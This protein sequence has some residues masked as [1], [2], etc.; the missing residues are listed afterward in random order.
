MTKK[1]EK[2]KP[3]LEKVTFEL[4]LKADFVSQENV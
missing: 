2:N 4:L 1:G 3:F